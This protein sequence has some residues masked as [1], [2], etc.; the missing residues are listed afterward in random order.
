M[1]GLIMWMVRGDLKSGS[2]CF[3]PVASR[4]D[5]PVMFWF[6]IVTTVAM[7]SMALAVGVYAILKNG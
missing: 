7:A 1:A 5:S 4:D 6:S 3:P 2:T